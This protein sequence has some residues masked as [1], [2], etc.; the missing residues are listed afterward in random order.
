MLVAANPTLTSQ[1]S[2][3]PDPSVLRNSEYRDVP[4]P[5]SAPSLPLTNLRR[6]QLGLLP[7]KAVRSNSA[8]L[9]IAKRS[10]VAPVS[11]N[12]YILVISTDGSVLDSGYLSPGFNGFGEYGFVQS[13]ASGA[14]SVTF[15]YDP[16]NPSATFDVTA[17]N[18][19]YPGVPFF[20]ANT[21][22]VYVLPTSSGAPPTSGDSS[23][24]DATLA[25]ADLESAIWSYDPFTTLLTP[26]W[27][28][29]DSSV[30]AAP[31]I[32]VPSELF[33]IFGKDGKASYAIESKD[34][35]GS[36]V[37]LRK[38]ILIANPPKES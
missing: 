6:L 18:D 1:R 27:T 28:N 22:L 26:Q 8:K 3:N 10:A 33:T 7:K 35:V 38:K 17:N 11:V 14:L 13:S 15:W 23:Y 29:T 30:I 12:D 19:V 9:S 21:V 5:R 24:Q 37:Q 20:G 36:A 2:L 32:Y 16:T 34:S 25:L 31:I 4:S